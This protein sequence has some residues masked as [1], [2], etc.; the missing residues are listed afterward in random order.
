MGLSFRPNQ[1][2]AQRHTE[3][4]IVAIGSIVSGPAERTMA[5]VVVVSGPARRRAK[6]ERSDEFEFPNGRTAEICG[7]HCWRDTFVPYGLTV[8]EVVIVEVTHNFV[9]DW[10]T[11]MW[12][13]QRVKPPPPE[14][15]N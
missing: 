9:G 10:A 5:R 6:C 2:A 3:Q 13:A 7:E 11:G 14:A 4:T 12:K 1:R 15:G 8:G